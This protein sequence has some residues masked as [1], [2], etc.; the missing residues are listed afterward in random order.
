[1]I[2]Y[3]IKPT[4]TCPMFAC[5]RF[6]EQVK[7]GSELA[8]KFDADGLLPVVTTNS[9]DGGM[10]MLEYMNR[11]ALVKTIQT[12]EAHYHVGYRSCFYRSGPIGATGSPVQLAFEERE[13]IFDPVAVYGDPNPTK[14]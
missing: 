7:E 9:S 12:G 14:L 3:Y 6:V 2:H 1:M 11:E 13:K 10:L 4:D 8:P 5:R